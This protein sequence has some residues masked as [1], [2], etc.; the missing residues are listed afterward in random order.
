MKKLLF[1]LT[2]IC[3]AFALQAQSPT[4]GP[5]T[6][7]YTWRN[8]LATNGPTYQWF[9]ISTIGTAVAG[10]SD[11]NFVGPFAIS[12]FPYYNSTPNGLY[13]GSNGYIAFTGVNIAST[14]AQFPAIP[15][16]GG[17]NNFI[18]P[19]L[20]DLTFG[21]ASSNPATCY[22]YNQGDT[23]CI[24]FEQVPF[25][26]NNTNQ[27]LGDNAFQIILNK[28]DS[29]I[30]FN[31]KKQVGRPDPTYTQNFVSIGIENGTGNDG[32]Q[33]SR[34]TTFPTANT[35]IKFYYPNVIQ[36]V[37]DLEL[38]WSDNEDNGGIFKTTS[39][40]YQV[41]ANVNNVGNQNVTSTITVNYQLID[42][43]GSAVRSGSTTLSSLNNGDDSTLNVG[44][45]F[46][47]AN[48]G[49]YSL[50]TYIS[51][52]TGDGVASNDTSEILVTVVDSLN[53]TTQFLDYTNQANTF[54]GLGWIGGN[55]GTAVYIEPPY[56][57]ARVVSTNFYITGLGTAPGFSSILYDDNGRGN[58]HGTILD[59]TFIPAASITTGTYTSNFLIP[60]N[61][62]INSGGVYLHWL[63]GGDGINIGR[64]VQSPASKRTYEV[65]F[66][67]WAPYRDIGTE[68][69]LMNIEIQP[70]S[71]VGIDEN[72][73]DAN[74]KIYPNPSDNYV[75]VELEKELTNADYELLD[76]RGRSVNAKIINLSNTQL[77][78][79][80][81]NLNAG[82]Y[83]LRINNRTHQI[84]FVD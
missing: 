24:T 5:D 46:T 6:F 30:T 14:A 15:T 49:R 32:L 23:I 70:V 31:Y 54:L 84:Q 62:V 38:A 25:W 78:V 27:Y 21:G 7:G 59:S 16:L 3:I 19:M 42:T 39:S 20:S 74:V 47:I 17:P 77:V 82:I 22:F 45:P 64:T 75:N 43:S 26:T 50:K 67:S 68:D 60:S 72:S 29:S 53:Q 8:N 12:G 41:Q 51:Q 55:G 4:G 63:M 80:K 73:K 71:T 79:Y 34:G 11:D 9:D 52:V 18:A 83:F 57:P 33:Y 1:L 65:L 48:P 69:F 28:R 40:P 56:Y 44:T 76:S 66:G 61:I 37:T 36:P 35:S 2:S 58:T 81:G 13:I 10:L